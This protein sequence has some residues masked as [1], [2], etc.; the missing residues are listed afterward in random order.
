MTLLIIYVS[1]ALSV[2]FLCSVMEAVLLSVSTAYV[3]QLGKESPLVGNK[4]REFKDDIENPLAAILSLN[5][6]AHTI[7]AAGAGAQAAHIFGDQFVGIISGILTL[8]ILIFSEII[9]KT[10]G[11]VYWRNLAPTIVRLL[12]PTIWIMWPLVKL[13]Q[14]MA[15]LITRGKKNELINREEFK[16]LTDLGA[17]EGIFSEQESHILKNLL[18]FRKLRVSDIMTPSNVVFDL[19]ETYT[20]NDILLRF[21]RIQFSRIPVFT[22]HPDNITGFVLKSTIL[23]KALENQG[24]TQLK[25]IKRSILAIPE[26]IKLYPLFNK[27]INERSHIAVVIDEYGGT[28]GIV[29]MEDVIETVL[30]ME[31]MDEIDRIEDM[32]KYAREQWEK[33]AAALGITREDKDTDES[34]G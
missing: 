25:S 12:L 29:T 27:L 7:G 13:S 28:A 19:D 20:I 10:L 18:K 22:D 11:A 1:I 6:I 23:T 14:F 21:P 15:K 33:R 5:T 34:S 30:G 4:L 3:A 2:S 26:S 24:T 32:Q 9:P 16:A 17:E 8:L 31:I